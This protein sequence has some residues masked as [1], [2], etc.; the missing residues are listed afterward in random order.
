MT[1]PLIADPAARRRIARMLRA[2]LAIA[3]A[4]AA[5]VT[6]LPAPSGSDD[7]ATREA[8]RGVWVAAANA[9]RQLG[10]WL[11]DLLVELARPIASDK[12]IHL[13][14]SFAL[15]L[16][17]LAARAVDKGTSRRAT[18][19][20]VVVLVI[21]AALGEL[22]QG[23]TGRIA[24]VG[25]VIANTAGAVLGAAAIHFGVWL[26]RRYWMPSSQP[27]TMPISASSSA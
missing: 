19:I 8:V 9:A 20:V 22:V 12:T 10:A 17:W 14:I 27:K 3:W 21:Y 16:L 6:H 4:G 2:A 7:P 11:P 1:P 18:G 25:D 24:D 13:V 26:W 15:A 23:I 5:V